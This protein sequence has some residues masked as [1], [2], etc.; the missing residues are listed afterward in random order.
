[1]MHHTKT[2]GDLGVLKAQLDMFQKGWVV[3]QPL[4]E[5]APFDLII[6]KDGE[7]K[8]V[9]VKARNINSRGQLVVQFQNTYSDS[10]GTHSIEVDKTQIDIYCIYCVQTDI[11]YYFNPNDFNK[12]VS[13]RMIPTKNNQS[14]NINNI[15]DYLTL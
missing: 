9:Q 6:Y 13:F 14:S 1:M 2:L 5:H 11:C 3:A 7:C 8:T 4:T 10:N 15:E 12:S